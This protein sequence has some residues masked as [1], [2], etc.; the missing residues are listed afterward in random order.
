VADDEAVPAS[1]SC[2]L[3]RSYTSRKL[4]WKRKETRRR[5]AARPDPAGSEPGS[6]QRFVPQLRSSAGSSGCGPVRAALLLRF[7]PSQRALLLAST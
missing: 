7:S 1:R 2:T 3:R 5:N 4:K 6:E